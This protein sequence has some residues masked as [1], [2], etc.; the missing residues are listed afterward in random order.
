M[1]HIQSRIDLDT[2]S[3]MAQS[4]TT[5]MSVVLGRIAADRNRAIIE[6]NPDAML[7]A[8]YAQTTSNPHPLAGIPIALKDNIDTGDRMQT[9]AGSPAL[10]TSRALAPSRWP[11]P[12]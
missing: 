9:T 10:L 1:S 11:K 5:L 2:I 8:E 4:P 6:V 3:A 7:L 12:T